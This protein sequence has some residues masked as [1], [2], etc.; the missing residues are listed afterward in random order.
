MVNMK[1]ILKKPVITEKSSRLQEKVNQHTFIVSK[2]ANKYQIKKTIENKFSVKIE[3]VN[4]MNYEGK[5]KRVGKFLGKK[6]DFKKAVVTLKK[7]FTID[8]NSDN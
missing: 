8:L 6:S 5:A 7:D 3:K 1:I 4:T 2:D